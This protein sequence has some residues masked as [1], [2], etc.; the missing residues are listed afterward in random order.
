MI[1]ELEQWRPGLSCPF[2]SVSHSGTVSAVQVLG[3]A[4]IVP[5]CLLA[6]SSSDTCP[7]VVSKA[8]YN[9]VQPRKS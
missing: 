9:T 1:L 2:S 3:D 8:L 4:R 5:V 6:R 7:P